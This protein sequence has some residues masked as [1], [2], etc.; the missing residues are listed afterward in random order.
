MVYSGFLRSLAK[1][2][3]YLPL[4]YS[5]VMFME[6]D[7]RDQCLIPMLLEKLLAVDG[8]KHREPQV[9]N[10]LRV[11]NFGALSLKYDTFIKPL[12]WG[13]GI[14]VGKVVGKILRARGDV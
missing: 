3:R 11:R 1:M 8:N 2:I 9:D 6:K 13:L 7:H 14:S 4:S 5:T 10:V 12:L